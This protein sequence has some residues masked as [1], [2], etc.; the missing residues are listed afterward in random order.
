MVCIITCV[1][2]F[3]LFKNGSNTLH[4]HV[5]LTCILLFTLFRSMLLHFNYCTY[6]MD[7]MAE[8]IAVA[9]DKTYIFLF[10]NTT[11]LVSL[12]WFVYCSF[13]ITVAKINICI[14][15]ENKLFSF[16]WSLSKLNTCRM[17]PLKF[18]VHFQW[19][20]LERPDC[21]LNRR[22]GTTCMYLYSRWLVCIV[23]VT[24][25]KHRILYF[26]DTF[27]VTNGLIYTVLHHTKACFFQ[28]INTNTAD[29]RAF[30]IYIAFK[31][32]IAC[33]SKIFWEPGFTRFV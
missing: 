27:F 14:D 8:K 9:K 28:R 2:V 6:K 10:C 16:H 30:L 19:W 31:A 20:N 26:N 22:Y 23:D 29:N 12:R 17:K 13:A 4:V 32:G 25:R 1:T 5:I 15:L 3:L 24:L 11:S 18:A 33:F 7:R 21:S